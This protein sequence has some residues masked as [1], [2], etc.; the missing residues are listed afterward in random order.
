MSSDDKIS[1]NWINARKS[2]GPRSA[3]GKSRASRNALRHG[4]A[5]KGDDSTLSADVERMAKA[6]CGDNPTPALYEQAI[7]IAECQLLIL[8]LRAVRAAAMECNRMAGPK[9]E[10]LNQLPGLP[11]TEERAVALAALERGQPRPAT[12]LFDRAAR[13]IRAADAQLAKA[14]TETKSIGPVSSAQ[15]SPLPTTISDAAAQ[16]IS[17]DQSIPRP[18]DDVGALQR[19]LPELA[20]LERYERR[21]LSRRKRAI[22]MFDAISIVAPFLDRKTKDTRS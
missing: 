2:T 3:R 12:R 18:Q 16:R 20:S 14:K 19:A 13:A 4:W 10:K 1:A 7:I 17:K 11:T 9:P 5:V 21:A 6:I 22:R 15:S 8:K